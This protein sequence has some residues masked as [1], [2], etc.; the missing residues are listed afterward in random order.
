MSYWIRIFLVTLQVIAILLAVSLTPS[1]ASAM[2]LCDTHDAPIEQ[3]HDQAGHAADQAVDNVSDHCA[4]HI[5]VLGDIGSADAE[6][7]FDVQLSVRS[8]D[9]VSLVITAIPEGLQRPPRA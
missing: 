3:A 4:S 9:M 8:W 5:C 7:P 2:I 1:N 6:L